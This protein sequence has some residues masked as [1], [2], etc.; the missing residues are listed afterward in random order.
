MSLPRT[1]LAQEMLRIYAIA[2]IIFC[3]CT[4]TCLAYRLVGSESLSDAL[5]AHHYAI[6]DRLDAVIVV[7]PTTPTFEYQTFYA[8]GYADEPEREQGKLQPSYA[9]TLTS[10]RP[11][12]TRI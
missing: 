6:N 8:I 10:P 9:T 1:P 3:I 2:A 4:D 5:V 12:Y 7:D 11:I